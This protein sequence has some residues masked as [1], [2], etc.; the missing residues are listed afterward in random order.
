[1]NL[2][3]LKAGIN[4]SLKALGPSVIAWK[5]EEGIEGPCFKMNFGPLSSSPG[6]NDTVNKHVVARIYYYPSDRD[7]CDKELLTMR[8]KLADL[9]SSHITIGGQVIKVK[10]Y[11]D[12]ITNNIIQGAF[13]VE[14]STDKIM[15]TIYPDMGYIEMNMREVNNGIS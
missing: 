12:D 9:F 8:E 5:K 1:M 4:L 6:M 3:E 13:E 7:D 15:E 14:Y 2:A 11:D 10:D